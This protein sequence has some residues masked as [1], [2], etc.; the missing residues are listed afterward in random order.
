[1]LGDLGPA[2]RKRY[3][4]KSNEDLYNPNIAVKAAWDIYTQAKGGPKGKKNGM[5]PWAA[6]TKSSYQEHIKRTRAVSGRR[7]PKLKPRLTKEYKLNDLRNLVTEVMNEE[8][9]PQQRPIGNTDIDK[10]NRRLKNDPQ[11]MVDIGYKGNIPDRDLEDNVT[12]HEQSVVKAKDSEFYFNAKEGNY[13]KKIIDK[14]GDDAYIVTHEK[15]S[16]AQPVILDEMTAESFYDFLEYWPDQKYGKIKLND[17]TA[18]WD[19]VKG[20]STRSPTSQHFHGNAIDLNVPFEPGSDEH[21]NFK[22]EALTIA[23]AVGFNSFGFGNNVLHMDTRPESRWW[24]YNEGDKFDFLN[25]SVQSIIPLD[26][27]A[28]R[29]LVY[30]APGSGKLLDRAVAK[31]KS[32]AGKRRVREMKKND[33]DKLIAEFLNENTGQGYGQYP[34]H[35]DSYDEDE[36][37]E[38]YIEEWKA[39]EIDLVRD[40]T[41]NTAIAVAKIL[42]KDLELFND[43]LDLAGQNQSIGT[44]ILRKLK[45]TK[46]KS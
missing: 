40:E 46:V 43:V 37:A 13:Y 14:L 24:I 22:H 23:T 26:S 45:E 5:Q 10:L 30:R 32:I 8:R 12:H 44:E 20:G 21:L 27:K 11:A 4:L 41:R 15:L 25:D 38:D 34:Y 39:L 28:F 7:I 2:R 17:K 36:P 16:T 33:L 18:T 6:S 42:V 31:L 29:D 35:S 9:A 19:A 1:M 3:K